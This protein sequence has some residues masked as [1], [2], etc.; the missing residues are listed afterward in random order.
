MAELKPLGKVN[1][2]HVYSVP[3][4]YSATDYILKYR[5]IIARNNFNHSFPVGYFSNILRTIDN[6]FLSV[7][8]V[9]SRRKNPSST[10]LKHGDQ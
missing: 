9:A 6:V 5:K 4:T 7:T 10:F 1:D 2:K 8:A 3:Q